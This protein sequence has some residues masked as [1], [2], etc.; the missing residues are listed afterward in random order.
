MGAHAS[1]SDPHAWY[2]MWMTSLWRKSVQSSAWEEIGRNHTAHS[3]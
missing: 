1:I 2:Y 3:G